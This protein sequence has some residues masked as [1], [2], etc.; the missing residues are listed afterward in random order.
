M[1]SF[2][3]QADYPH[4]ALLNE[5]DYPVNAAQMIAAAARVLAQHDRDP[6]T[7][8]TIVIADDDTIQGLNREFR[9]IPAPTDVLSFPAEPLPAELADA[10]DEDEPPYLGDLVIAHPYAS[11][12]AAREGHAPEDSFALLVVHGTLHLLGYD[13][14]T[15]ENRAQMWAAQERALL[16]LHISPDIVPALEASGTT[17]TS[18]EDTADGGQDQ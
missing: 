17:A 18:G 11:A 5:A 9:G 1:P 6:D 8:M 16:A 10:L 13:H 3:M 4:I 12:Q 2:A 14:D 7:G 15:A